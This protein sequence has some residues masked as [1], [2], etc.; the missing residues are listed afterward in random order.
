MDRSYRVYSLGHD[1]VFKSAISR[2]FATDDE[3]VAYAKVALINWTA[4]ELW[5]TDRLV[6]RFDQKVAA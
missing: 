2:E 4:V 5:Q 3:A 1:G 6:G